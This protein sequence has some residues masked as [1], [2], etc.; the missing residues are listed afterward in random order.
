MN[1]ARHPTQVLL[2]WCLA[3]YFL[4]GCTLVAGRVRPIWRASWSQVSYSAPSQSEPY[5]SP[6]TLQVLVYGERHET[7][8]GVVVTARDR[9]GHKITEVTDLTGTVSFALIPG[10][11]SLDIRMAGLA[12]YHRTVEVRAS[13]VCVV[14]V[15]LAYEWGET[16]TQKHEPANSSQQPTAC[17]SLARGFRPSSLVD[18]GV[19]AAGT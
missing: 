4:E 8:P 14:T 13:S 2:I 19:T 15:Y 9:Q 12:G 5:R 17:R 3:P 1:R 7:L 10:T 16:I 11:S 18:S 6:I